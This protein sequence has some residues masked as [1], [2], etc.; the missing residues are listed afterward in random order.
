MNVYICTVVCCSSPDSEMYK[1]DNI[2]FCFTYNYT[3]YFLNLFSLHF[4]MIF[5]ISFNEHA[6]LLLITLEIKMQT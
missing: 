4:R 6:T 2:F 3:F 5:N 1:C